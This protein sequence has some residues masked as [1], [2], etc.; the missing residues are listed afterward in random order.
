MRSVLILAAASPEP[1]GGE[2]QG[3]LF[4][5]ALLEIVHAL[6]IPQTRAFVLVPWSDDLAPFVATGI[7]DSAPSFDPE[8]GT[9]ESSRSGLVP[10]IPLG[11]TLSEQSTVFFSSSHL[12]LERAVPM[13]FE[14]V[15][16]DYPPTDVVVL[17]WPKK[18]AGQGSFQ[19]LQN[20]RFLVFGSL[21]SPQ[22]IVADL[23]IPLEKVEDLERRLTSESG[24]IREG[25][26]FADEREREAGL[27]PFIPFG[28]LIQD[29]LD[30]ILPDD[31]TPPEREVRR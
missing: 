3:D 8:S 31:E 24:E 26:E 20:A 23:S 7:I 14:R 29:A 30:D 5:M 11:S 4:D 27:E 13:P 18:Y 16:Q 6:D 25:A 15:I 17:T 12:A 9:T 22:Q 28:L 10:Y 21:T 2:R 1:L 19:N